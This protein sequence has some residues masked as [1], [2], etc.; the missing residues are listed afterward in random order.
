MCQECV[1]DG[2]MTQVELDEAVAAGDRSVIPI[3]D[4]EPVEFLMAV[5]DMAAKA[6]REGM[7]PAAAH[8]FM[9]EQIV[10]YVDRREA[11]GKPATAGELAKVAA[12]SRSAASSWN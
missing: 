7:T 8:E 9:A 6:V 5:S 10:L 3:E 1:K 2:R 4:L 12:W 11:A